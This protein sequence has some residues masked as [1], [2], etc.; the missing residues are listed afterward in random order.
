MRRQELFDCL[1]GIGEKERKVAERL[2]DEIVFQEGLLYELRNES[3]VKRHPK[4]P[5]LMKPSPAY[6][7]YRET[8]QLYVLNV[9]ALMSI[10][11]KNKTKE[12]SPLAKYLE[13][14]EK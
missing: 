13:L 9:K 12:K 6:K 7:M 2:V 5:A 10:A 3:M 1:D 11:N 8:A 14:F 4:N